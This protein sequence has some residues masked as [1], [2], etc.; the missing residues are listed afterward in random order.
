MISS[1]LYKLSLA[2]SEAAISNDPKVMKIVLFAGAQQLQAKAVSVAILESVQN[3]MKPCS[4][5]DI[6]H[7]VVDVSNYF[8]KEGAKS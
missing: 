8:A 1:D 5:D 2:M 7:A 3:T 4:G 6:D